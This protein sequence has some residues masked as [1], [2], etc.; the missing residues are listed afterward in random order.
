MKLKMNSLSDTE[1][2]DKLYEASKA[3]VKIQ[4]E[5]RGICSLI[6]GVP[7]MS[8]NIEAISIVDNYLE[9]SRIYI[10]GNARQTEVYIS[11]ADIMTR[12]LDG[13]VEVTCPILDE[14]IKQELIDNF[15]LGWKGN[16]KARFHSEKLDNKYRQRGNNPVFRAQLETYNY[17]KNKVD[18]EEIV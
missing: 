2:I 9:H 4:L 14:E 11:S 8:E 12:N 1:M 16:V 7:G 6:P 13:R 3:G 15:D 5:V 17:Y 10:F 18:Q